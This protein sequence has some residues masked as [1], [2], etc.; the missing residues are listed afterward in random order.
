[1]SDIRTTAVGN[2]SLVRFTTSN[3]LAI[4]AEWT[5]F[6]GALVY[7]F[8]KG[9]ARSAG[10]ASLAL[11]DPDS[12]CRTRWPGRLRIASVRNRCG[13]RSYARADACTR[14]CGPR[15]VRRLAR[16]RRGGL[17]RRSGHGVHLP[18]ACVRCALTSHRAVGTRTDRGERVGELLR[19]RR[20]ARGVVGGDN[21][22]R[23]RG[24]RLGAGRLRGDFTGEHTHHALAQP[25][26]LTPRKLHR[27][28][29]VARVPFD[30]C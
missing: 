9:G 14:R 16:G 30:S 13:S 7:A 28:R 23:S 21:P 15:G 17:L 12:G 22:A 19:E 24:T 6:V 26:G 5:F 18:R 2:G 29:R 11:A 25:H 27:C 3:L 10:V 1:M 4:I 20:H 8:D